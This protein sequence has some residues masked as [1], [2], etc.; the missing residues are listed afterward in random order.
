MSAV[1]QITHG[2][3][4]SCICTKIEKLE[5]LCLPPI[6]EQGLAACGHLNQRVGV[7]K[8][9]EDNAVCLHALR[10]LGTCDAFADAGEKRR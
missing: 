2:K 9:V 5:V 3:C 4:S 7:G 8:L 1:A 10:E 6:L